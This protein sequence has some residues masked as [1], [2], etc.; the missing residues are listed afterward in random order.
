M[1]KVSFDTN[2]LLDHPEVLDSEEYTQIVLPSAV[3]EEIDGLKNST[4]VG[5]LAREVHRKLEENLSRITFDVSDD[6]SENMPMGWDREKR[7]NKII[8]CALKHNVKLISNDINVRIKAQ[9]V[10]IEFEG[11]GDKVVNNDYKGFVEVTLTDEELAEFYLDKTINRF[12]LILNQYLII[13]HNDE[14]VDKYKWNGI[15]YEG[16]SNKKIDSMM[17][18]KLKPK[19]IYQELVINSLLNEQFTAISGRAGT[20]KSLLS[21]MYAM[22]AI[23]NG[24]YDTLVILFNPSKIRNSENMGFYGGNMLEKAKQQ[25]IGHILNTKFGDPSMVDNLILQG[26]LKL[27]PIS[28]CRGMEITDNQILYITEAQ[29][30]D[31][32]LMKICLSRVSKGAKVIIEGDS[33]SQV[34]NRMYEGSKNGMNRMVEIFKGEDLFSYIELQNVWRSRIADIVDKM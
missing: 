26:K 3:L 4:S 19:D 9:A 27:I 31:I 10:G 28:D 20:G 7:D 13:R 29:N 24:K 14:I 34:D 16:I 25:N 23:Q 22:Y 30:T 11:Y 15:E 21:L 5:H 18:G 1:S 12:N 8:M 33:K 2:V 32:D 17:F 6:F